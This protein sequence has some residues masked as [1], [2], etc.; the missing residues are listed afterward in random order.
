M[1]R[2][3]LVK[4]VLQIQLNTVYTLNFR[5]VFNYI[6]LPTKVQLLR[7]LR[8]YLKNLP[9]TFCLYEYS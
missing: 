1:Y 8:M 6:Q 4:L 9:V 2:Y 7:I 3:V 5:N